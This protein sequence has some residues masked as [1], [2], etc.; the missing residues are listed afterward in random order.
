MT[1]SSQQQPQLTHFLC[2]PLVTQKARPQLA[3][4]LLAFQD[5]VTRSKS[6]GGFDLPPDAVRPMGTV[7]FTLGMM[8]F[9]EN[10]GLDRAVDVLRSLN[11]RE[12]LA[13]VKKPAM[14]GAEEEDNSAA[15][16]QPSQILLTLKGL[17]TTQKPEKSTVLY[18][19]PVDPLGTLQEFSE[20]IKTVFKEGGLLVADTRPLLLHATI[21][22]T[23]YVKSKTGAG[24]SKKRD[25]KVIDHVQAIIDRYED[26]VWMRDVPLEK[27]AICKMSAKPVL[28]GGEVVDMAYEEEATNCL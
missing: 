7:H 14:P 19:P 20:E 6:L 4:S 23:I 26:Q 8:S 5:D 24:R 9:P 12:I 16:G 25:K 21:V 15:R 10:E 18:A 28:E 27:V 1:S 3:T 13:G 2:I 11:L 17:H 22:N